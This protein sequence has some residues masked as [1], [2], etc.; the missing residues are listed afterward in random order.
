MIAG[1]QNFAKLMQQATFLSENVHVLIFLI[2]TDK[3]FLKTWG[4]AGCS[5][6]CQQPIRV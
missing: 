3:K 4:V 1:S 5:V 2:F 6:L